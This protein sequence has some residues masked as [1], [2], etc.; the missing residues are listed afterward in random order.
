MGKFDVRNFRVLHHVKQLQKYVL[1]ILLFVDKFCE[2][3]NIPYYLGEGTLLGA[4]RH[5]GFIPWDDDFDIQMPRI[6]YEKLVLI[7][8]TVLIAFLKLLKR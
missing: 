3:N 2:E 6:D 7:I 4:V 5:N 8:Q 1:E